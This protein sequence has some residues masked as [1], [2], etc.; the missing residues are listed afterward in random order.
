MT[1]LEVKDEA[2]LEKVF[3]GF[4]Q[5]KEHVLICLSGEAD[6]PAGLIGGIVTRCGGIP[7][8]ADADPRWISLLKHGFAQRCGCIVGKAGVLLGLS[9]LS[10]RTGIPLFARNC[11][12]LDEQPDE[13]LTETIQFGLDCTIRA[14]FCPKAGKEEPDAS[15]VHMIRELR[16]WTSILDYRLERTEA[17]LS[18]E[19]VTFP[20]ARLPKLPS[21]ARLSSRTWQPDTDCP[22]D[23]EKPLFLPQTH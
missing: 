1:P 15:L 5:K 7:V 16:R 14:C 18:L 6:S 22:F 8:Q 3:R 10:Q 4:L 11:V 13:W 9:K 23:L 17:G 20:G 19:M 12:I 21:L 2:A